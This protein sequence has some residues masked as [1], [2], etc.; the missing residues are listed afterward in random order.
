[1]IRNRYLVGYEALFR[2]NSSANAAYRPL[3]WFDLHGPAPHSPL[4]LLGLLDTGADY[5]MLPTDAADDLDID[6]ESCPKECLAVA[7]GR[8]ISVPKTIVDV[9][10]RGKRITVEAVFGA[11]NQPPLIGL[12]TIVW[13]M[14][15]GIDIRGWLYRQ[16]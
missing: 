11:N 12:G 2:W 8:T 14:R 7:S 15:L 6:I 9:T 4:P 1:M 10:I 3:C 5:L 13:A 16:P